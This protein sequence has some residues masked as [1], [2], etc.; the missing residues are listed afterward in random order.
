MATSFRVDFTLGHATEAEEFRLDSWSLTC[1]LPK[2]L[3]D[4]R[5][6]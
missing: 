6:A 2:L 4:L 1:P 5:V 3:E